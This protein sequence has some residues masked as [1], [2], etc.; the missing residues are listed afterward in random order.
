MKI[1][2]SQTKLKSVKMFFSYSQIQKMRDVFFEYSTCV[3]NNNCGTMFV[4]EYS[5]R[6][7]LIFHTLTEETF[8]E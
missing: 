6:D 3:E 4:T 5:I 1:R 2:Q 8:I 7:E